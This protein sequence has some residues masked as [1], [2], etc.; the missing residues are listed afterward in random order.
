L[1]GNSYRMWRQVRRLLVYVSLLLCIATLLL[2]GRSYFAQDLLELHRRG[3]RRGRAYD[4]ISGVVSENG[5][6]GGGY[7][8]IDHPGVAG[9]SDGWQFVTAAGPNPWPMRFAL[10]GF[11]Y[12]NTTLTRGATGTVYVVGFTAPHALPAVLLAIGPALA[13]RRAWLARRRRRRI[14]RGLC[15]ACGYDLR[16]SAERCPECG[17]MAA[18]S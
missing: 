6:I 10:L 1:S 3:D 15:T 2:W 9:F 18:R 5:S 4:D 8:R 14:A 16:E 13:A 12:W 17:I 11:G 7:V